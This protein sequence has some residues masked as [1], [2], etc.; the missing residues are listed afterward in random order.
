MG[1]IK[2]QMVKRTA[3]QVLT[4]GV[5]T[6]DFNK[7]KLVLKDTMPSKPI[8]NKV[9]GYLARLTKINRIIKEKEAKSASTLKPMPSEAA[10]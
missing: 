5:F 7:N 6:E 2:S 9:A 4:E 10:E 8:R 1:R 3:R